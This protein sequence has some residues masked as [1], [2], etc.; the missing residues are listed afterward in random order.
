MTYCGC[1]YCYFNLP[2]QQNVYIIMVH[3]LNKHSAKVPI[4]FGRESSVTLPSNLL[5]IRYTIGIHSAQFNA[6]ASIMSNDNSS[7]QRTIITDNYCD[8]TTL[9]FF[10]NISPESSPQPSLR[11]AY[12]ALSLW[13]HAQALHAMMLH[14]WSKGRL[15]ITNDVIRTRRWLNMPCCMRLEIVLI[16]WRVSKKIQSRVDRFYM[17][18]EP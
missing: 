10:S 15:R 17:Y 14:A 11:L 12:I 5:L 18:P 8:I 9:I 13:E 1:V 7:I 4:S 6:R 2:S 16:A 3:D